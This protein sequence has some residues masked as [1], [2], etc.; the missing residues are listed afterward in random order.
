MQR[1]VGW[2]KSHAAHELHSYAGHHPA[3]R[4]DDWLLFS[5]CVWTCQMSLHLS[6]SLPCCAAIKSAHFTIVT[7]LII[8]SLLELRYWY[9]PV[10]AWIWISNREISDI[11]TTFQGGW[12]SLGMSICPRDILQS[13]K[14]LLRSLSKIFLLRV[15]SWMVF[16][17]QDSFDCF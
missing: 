8:Q 11:S 2:R 13:V 12:D 3:T 5:S 15:Q 1:S 7:F 6:P 17:G 4:P 10:D 14:C 9:W 16:P